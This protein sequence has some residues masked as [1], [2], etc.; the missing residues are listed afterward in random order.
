[1]RWLYLQI[2]PPKN[3]HHLTIVLQSSRDTLYFPYNKE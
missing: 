1:M 3:Y 2:Y